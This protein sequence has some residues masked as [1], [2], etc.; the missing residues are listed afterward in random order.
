MLTKVETTLNLPKAQVYTK[1][2]E[3]CKDHTK[4]VEVLDDKITTVLKEGGEQAY[5]LYTL[6]IHTKQPRQ[7]HYEKFE[8]I[9]DKL[10]DLIE[11]LEDL[12]DD[13]ELPE[14]WDYH[15]ETYDPIITS[16]EIWMLVSI[17]Q[18]YTKEY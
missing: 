11:D 5:H 12:L 3:W 1:T 8:E 16:N 7:K 9:E 6:K 18:E 14:N 15:I 17:T 2:R 13:V 4:Q 10:V